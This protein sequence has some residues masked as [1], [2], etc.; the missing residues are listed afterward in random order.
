VTADAVLVPPRPIITPLTKFFW[1]G[2]DER[3]LMILQCD[4]CGFYVHVPRP[5]CRK[6]LSENLSASEVSGKAT[7]YTYTVAVQ[8]FHP[9][10][11]DKVPYTLAVVEL[12][13]QDGLRLTTQIIECPESDLKVGLPLE[14]VWTEVAPDI[15]LPY[16]RPTAV[17]S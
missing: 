2:I 13:E 11:V 4:E 14:M 15:T 17:S 10:Y 1:D 12:A 3:R 8:A 5:V 7:L 6:C 9:F 16:F